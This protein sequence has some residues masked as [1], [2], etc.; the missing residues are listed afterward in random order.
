MLGTKRHLGHKHSDNAKQKMSLAH[1]GKQAGEKHP[2]WKGNI[3]MQNLKHRMRSWFLWKE[4]R[5]AVFERDNY[6]CKNC[7]KQGGILEPNH[8]IP[9]R[10][11]MSKAFDKNNGITLCRLCHVKTFWKEEQFAERF[12]QLIGCQK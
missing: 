9:L 12:F 8:I 1:I 10:S 5:K 7:N 4:W 6:T 2:N 11:D 3:S